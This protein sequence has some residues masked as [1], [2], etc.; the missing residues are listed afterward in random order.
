[1]MNQTRQSKKELR[2]AIL[3]KRSAQGKEQID[4]KSKAICSY[5]LQSTLYKKAKYVMI[6]ASMSD[7]VQTKAL[8]DDV[9]QSGKELFL[10]YII[11]LTEGQMEAAQVRDL[12]ELVVGKYGILTPADDALHFT[13]PEEI[14]LILVPG[15][16][17]TRDKNRLGMGGGFYDRFLPQ[18]VNALKVGLG[19]NF[20]LVDRM[21]VEAHDLK[22]DMLVT[23][24]GWH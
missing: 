24:D 5:I 12:S 8:L 3:E 13:S 17:F 22:L 11:D 2:K 4:K 19:F 6:F 9:L 21:P 14:D 16:A 23:E 7:E 10:P 1:M 18:A 20:Q 15:A